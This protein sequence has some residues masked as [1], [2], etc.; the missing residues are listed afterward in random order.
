MPPGAR[1]IPHGRPTGAHQEALLL[2]ERLKRLAVGT[3][4]GREAS[5]ELGG[6][7]L[8][9]LRQPSIF[10]LQLGQLLLQA[11][12]GAVEVVHLC[13]EVGVLHH[14]GHSWRTRDLWD[15]GR[16]FVGVP[17]L[18]R[19]A[20]VGGKLHLRKLSLQPGGSNLSSLPL[21]HS[22]LQHPGVLGGRLRQ[23]L[24]CDLAA[25]LCALQLALQLRSVLLPGSQLGGQVLGRGGRLTQLPGVLGGQ[26]LDLGIQ[27]GLKLAGCRHQAGLQ[28]LNLG[29][30]R[31]R[32]GLSLVK[33]FVPRF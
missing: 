20:S 11:S 17:A 4:H 9:G 25:G 1:E 33:P 16:G 22:L 10:G 5:E 14:R 32:R 7:L 19:F 30:T 18:R 2:P 13:Q 15:R 26:E 6:G 27:A 23:R 28:A 31:C 24:L 29:G 3:G 12:H 21:D 8:L